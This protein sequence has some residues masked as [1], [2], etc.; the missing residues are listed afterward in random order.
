MLV[1]SRSIV[2]KISSCFTILALYFL[3]PIGT[4]SVALLELR[5]CKDSSL[6]AASLVEALRLVKK[7]FPKTCFFCINTLPVASLAALFIN[8]PIVC[9][10]LPWYGVK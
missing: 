10:G 9:S 7:I 2:S 6:L 4:N 1:S 3:S 5:I 8:S